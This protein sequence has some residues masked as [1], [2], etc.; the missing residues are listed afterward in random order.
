MDETIITILCVLLAIIVLLP[1]FLFALF[2]LIE[3][4]KEQEES[5]YP[6]CTCKDVNECEMWCNAKHLF[7]KDSQDGKI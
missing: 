1:L 5:E 7:T 6:K 2:K 3:F 4:F